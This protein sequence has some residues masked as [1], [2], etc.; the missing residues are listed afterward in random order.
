MLSF[1]A[2]LRPG[3]LGA[4]RFR[5]WD[6]NVYQKLLALYNDDSVKDELQKGELEIHDTNP[7]TGIVM[8]RTLGNRRIY[9]ALS[10]VK[11]PSYGDG[12]VWFG[13]DG[14]SLGL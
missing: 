4:K 7:A 10:F 1:L 2:F 9:L 8:S 11:A 6:S 14:K 5:D 3:I 13:V 12:K